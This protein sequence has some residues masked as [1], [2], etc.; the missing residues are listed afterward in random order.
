MKNILKNIIFI[1]LYILSFFI[2]QRNIIIIGGPDN[3]RYGGNVKYLYEFLSD[4]TEYEVFWLT[5]SDD[6]M[7]YLQNKD[8]KYLS[9]KNYF[10]KIITTL[11][12]KYVID[13][14]TNF[15][16]PFNYISRMKNIIKIST[17][18]G[19]GPKLTL[20]G[21]KDEQRR[22]LNLFDTICFCTDYA[23]KRIGTDEFYLNDN[24]GKVFGQPKH[25]ILR[26]SKHVESIYLNRT[27]C[28]SI[29][30]KR[31]NDKYSVIYY[32]PTWRD[33]NT[34][35]PLEQINNFS[36][37][38]FNDF[39]EMNNIYFLYTEHIL[40]NFTKLTSQYSHIKRVTLKDYSLF[41][42][43]ELL[44]ESDMMITDYSTLS[45]DY[46]ILNKP[47]LF[48]ITDVEEIKLKKGFIEDPVKLMPG[49]IITEFE[50][51]CS[52]IKRYIHNAELYQ[53]DYKEKLD[54]LKKKYVGPETQNSRQMI[55]N[56]ILSR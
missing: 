9:N 7:K 41:D 10:K 54:N 52:Y 21:N 19:S 8:L 24:I 47:Q 55:T 51:L 28:S 35:L 31:M 39:L 11:K 37:E 27:W 1:F 34:S 56:Y 17:M 3:K 49:A 33:T 12:C 46:S 16:N 25:D 22:I 53:T 5:E 32:C 45:S 18:H 44:M 50:D 6:I 2:S 20:G 4:N 29:L 42:N 48:V 36:L 30:D 15:Y 43:L 26:D 40:S 14:G 13:S 23:K 38:K